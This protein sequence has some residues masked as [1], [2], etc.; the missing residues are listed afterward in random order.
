MPLQHCGVAIATFACLLHPI[1][2]AIILKAFTFGAAAEQ[3]AEVGIVWLSVELQLPH[4]TTEPRFRKLLLQPQVQGWK[5]N[6]GNPPKRSKILF[7]R[8]LR[9]PNH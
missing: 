6:L 7:K 4:H 3:A 9:N 5:I 2:D 8:D 1:K